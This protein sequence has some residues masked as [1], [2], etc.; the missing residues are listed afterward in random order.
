MKRMSLRQRVELNQRIR[1]LTANYDFL[2]ACDAVTQ[3]E[4]ALSDL[5]VARLYLEWG[6]DSVEGLL[7]DGQKATVK[8]LIESGPESL[9]DE[10]VR[11]IQADCGLTDDER[12]NS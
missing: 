9:A 7:I 8:L 6:L 12:K 4:A 10:I 11:S 2:K 1:E 3:V 5:L